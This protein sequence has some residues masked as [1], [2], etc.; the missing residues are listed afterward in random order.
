MD[1]ALAL[2]P[3]YFFFI[4]F[5]FLVTSL[6]LFIPRRK[7]TWWTFSGFVFWCQG[8]KNTCWI[9]LRLI[10]TT[11]IARYSFAVYLLPLSLSCICVRM[12]SSSDMSPFCTEPPRTQL[13]ECKPMPLQFLKRYRMYVSLCLSKCLFLSTFQVTSAL[14]WLRVKSH[15]CMYLL[16]SRDQFEWSPK[17]LSHTYLI[18]YWIRNCE[19]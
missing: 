2:S 1:F 11:A 8:L 15:M 6:F 19:L 10:P 18:S 4:L 9:L 5:S 13:H 17:D 16:K 12:P 7:S 3:F 14:S